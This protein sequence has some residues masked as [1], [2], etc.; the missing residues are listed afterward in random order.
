MRTPKDNLGLFCEDY[1]PQLTA[2][3]LV[4]VMQQLK[5]DVKALDESFS[6]SA[7]EALD[8]LA[9]FL[10]EPLEYGWGEVERLWLDCVDS[11]KC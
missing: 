11:L 1:L 10:T 7:Q 9:E 8:Y 3:E 4:E 5:A 2:S 6:R